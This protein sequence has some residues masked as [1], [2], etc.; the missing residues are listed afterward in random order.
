MRRYAI[1]VTRQF[2][3]LGRPIAKIVAERLGI[4]YYDRD[5][6]EQTAKNLNLSVSTIENEEEKA[7]RPF[8]YMRYPLGKG[9]SDIQDR[10]FIEQQ[11]IITSLVEKESC[12]IVGRCSDY[13][14]A[15]MENAIH[16]YIYAPYAARLQN[17]VE[18]LLMSEEEAKKSIQAID[19]ARASYHMHYAGYMPS[20]PEHKHI[21]INSS[22][23]GKDGTAEF[24]VDAIK[25]KF[26][27]K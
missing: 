4:N 8:L 6:V 27:I 21:L 16:I 18:E 11:K 1:T 24:L 15:N 3:S 7:K 13:I 26:E 19:K 23:Y 20:D 22:L 12:I 2:G 9:T 17:C 10:I 14:L 5:I 25:R